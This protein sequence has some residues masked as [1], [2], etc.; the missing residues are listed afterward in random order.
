MGLPTSGQISMKDIIDEK[1]GNTASVVNV[2]MQGMH[3]DGVVDDGNVDRALNTDSIQSAAHGGP[4][5]AEPHSI[6]EFYGFAQDFVATSFNGTGPG[7]VSSFT[8]NT[9]TSVNTSSGFLAGQADPGLDLNTSTFKSA[10]FWEMNN[11]HS[12]GN[13][14]AVQS[15]STASI[16]IGNDKTNKRIMLL[17]LKD[18]DADAAAG[19]GNNAGYILVPYVNLENATWTY[20]YEYDTSTQGY[21]SANSDIGVFRG[22][23][24]LQGTFTTSSTYRTIPSNTG[25]TYASLSLIHI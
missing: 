12:R 5:G 24:G 8:T 4:D 3:L 20:T 16:R 11:N 7:S 14:P 18:G 10:T 15:N 1:K 23:P 2:S 21:S 13:S 9:S 17:L 19:A 25:G 22:N 6:D